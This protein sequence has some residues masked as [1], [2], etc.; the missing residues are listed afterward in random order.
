MSIDDWKGL[1]SGRWSLLDRFERDGRR[2]VVAQENMPYAPGPDA[3]STRE[4]Q[5]LGYAALGHH[6]KLIAYDLGI[7]HSTVRV[8]MAR[9]ASKLGAR[10]REEAVERFRALSRVGGSLCAAADES[11]AAES[12]CAAK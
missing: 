8:L 11:C 3:L 2:Y 4:T 1:V 10:S 9:A 6:N 7:S 12:S 5:V